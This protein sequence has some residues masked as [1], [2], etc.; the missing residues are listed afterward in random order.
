MPPWR[1]PIVEPPGETDATSA[2]SELAVTEELTT[3]DTSDWVEE[4]VVEAPI[5]AEVIAEPPEVAEV[6]EVEETEESEEVAAA[7]ANL[8]QAVDEFVSETR[9]P[10]FEPT[11]EL[12]E[13]TAPSADAYVPAT[14]DDELT[15][16][17]PIVA[18]AADRL[19]QVLLAREST[20][21][22]AAEATVN[23]LAAHWGERFVPVAAL[24]EPEEIE[25]EA[26]AAASIEAS[27]E[28]EEADADEAADPD[29]TVIPSWPSTTRASER[30]ALPAGDAPAPPPPPTEAERA[31]QRPSQPS[32]SGPPSNPSG[33]PFR[34][35]GDQLPAGRSWPTLPR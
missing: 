6:V 30:S 18:P 34:T 26:E 29:S 21:E 23:E 1:R 31:G 16:T 22:S 35:A 15:E 32:R 9:E 17:E 25:N 11:S 8:E 13:F 28:S 20:E 2:E 12:E 24:A 4:D 10:E 14:E 7:T 33:A 5:V 27:E 19:D 3:T